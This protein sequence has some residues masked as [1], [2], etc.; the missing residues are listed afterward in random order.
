M[1]YFL[2]GSTRTPESLHSE[3]ELLTPPPPTTPLHHQ[4]GNVSFRST[5][6]L[7]E[8]VVLA[9]LGA[10]RPRHRVALSV[11]DPVLNEARR[12]G[13]G[14]PRPVEVGRRVLVESTAGV[15]RAVSLHVTR[16]V[17]DF[18]VGHKSGAFTGCMYVGQRLCGNLSIYFVHHLKTKLKLD[19]N[20]KSSRWL[21]RKHKAAG[22]APVITNDVSIQCK[23]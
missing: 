16:K 8:G 4:P 3:F 20:A 14:R 11:D 13:T 2:N 15:R 17:L 21:A 5:G 23:T 12:G 1:R 19:R 9:L 6:R 10:R 22:V 7:D 18:R